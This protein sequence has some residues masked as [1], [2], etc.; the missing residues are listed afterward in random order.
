M[1][2]VIAAHLI[3]LQSATANAPEWLHVIPAGT[4][5]GVDGRGPYIL[6]NA[7]AL[8][9][10]FN[11]EQ[12][13]LPVDENHSTDLAG[14]KGFSAPARGWI[15]ELQ[16]RA[17]GIWGRVEWTTEGKSLVEGKSYGYLSPVFTHTPKA[18]FQVQKMLRVALTND[19]NLSLTALHSNSLENS[20]DIVA[21]RKAL[22]LPETADETA[23][24]AAITASHTASTSQAALMNRVA[25]AIGV[26]ATAEGEA[27]V[28]ALQ[29][30]LKPV[31]TVEAENAELKATVSSLNSRLETFITTN[32][33]ER[34]VSTVDAAIAAGK[35]VPALRDHMISRHSKNPAEVDAEIKLMPSINAGGLGNRQPPA[36]GETATAEELNVA[37]MMGVDPEAFKKQHKSLFGKEA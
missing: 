2:N 4:F 11:A 28:T 10:L 22:G 6:N 27:L 34:A 3:A 19:P 1:H 21:L 24:L 18:P 5:T 32:A 7:A 31:G 15:V 12:R 29:A 37:S 14:K 25:E 13:K 20:M 30:K 9:D 33:Q 35:I 26:E 16:A 36:N 17:D 23:I 8:I